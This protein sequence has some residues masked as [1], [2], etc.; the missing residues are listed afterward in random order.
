MGATCIFGPPGTGKTESLVT[1]A[2]SLLAQGRTLKFLSHTKAAAEECGMR[3]GDREIASTVHSLCFK[4][5][6]FGGKNVVSD[7]RKQT[8]SACV[9]VPMRT[10]ET[11]RMEIGDDYL[12]CYERARVRGLNPKEPWDAAGRPGTWSE[13]DRFIKAYDEWKK[14]YG[15]IDFADML[16]RV[17]K[18]G[19]LKIDFDT[20]IVDEAQDLSPLQ[21]E[22]IEKIAT[23]VQQVYV[24]GDDDQAIFEW[25]GADP[26]GMDEFG[27]HHNAHSVVLN[28]SHRVPRNQ[29]MLAQRLIRRVSRRVPKDYAPRDFEGEMRYHGSIDLVP[30]RTWNRGTVDNPTL[31]L[32]RDKFK[33]YEI[34]DALL[35]YGIPF[36]TNGAHALTNR[37]Y[38]RA[39]VTWS[40]LQRNVPINENE[41][42]QLYRACD[43]TAK[44]LIAENDFLQLLRR[45]WERSITG[46]PEAARTYY[47]MCDPLAKPRITLST[48]HG[49]KGREADNVVLYLSSSQRVQ[50][51]YDAAPDPEHRLMYVAVTRAKRELHVID[52]Q[53]AYPLLTQAQW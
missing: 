37:P 35:R 38:G 10:Y 52:G 29:F 19:P 45:G 46:M 2:R 43:D 33:I 31:V 15:L 18:G 23:Q 32:C 40:K 13:Y 22:V 20:L 3:I 5:L 4:L 24:A 28:Q 53:G 17:L 1:E 14:T 36:Q 7:S 21:W 6:G 12:G 11:A 9:N 16:T 49:S 48:I 26:H 27:N 8:F 42:Q 47:N 30:F 50:D 25:G 41:R 44:Q 34:E 39:M 51:A